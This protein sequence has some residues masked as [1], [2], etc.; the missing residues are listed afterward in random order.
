[1]SMDILKVASLSEKGKISEKDETN[2]YEGKIIEKTVELITRFDME[3]PAVFMLEAIK[4]L[5]FVGG[6]FARFFLAP[7]LPI[8]GET[9]DDVIATLEREDNI[10]KIIQMIEKKEKEKEKT[11]NA[12]KE[13][14]KEN[15]SSQEAPM[16]KR[17]F[18]L[19]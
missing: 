18:W 2:E 5:V 17:R 14:E 13:A 9:S 19:F 10:E 12:M 15:A 6:Q 8:F 16:K 4:P 3:G 1:M 7:F 11:Q